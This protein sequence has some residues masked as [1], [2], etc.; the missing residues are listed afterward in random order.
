MD[1]LVILLI[2]LTIRTYFPKEKQESNHFHF[3]HQTFCSHVFS[4]LWICTCIKNFIN[5]HA[6]GQ[7]MK[8]KT[9]S[10][11][12]NQNLSFLLILNA[13][14]IIFF[15]YFTPDNHE[16]LRKIYS[17]VFNNFFHFFNN[18]P[19]IYSFKNHKQRILCKTLYQ[20]IASFF[21]TCVFTLKRGGFKTKLLYYHQKTVNIPVMNSLKTTYTKSNCQFR[22]PHT[23][24]I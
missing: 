3:L 23:T 5:I 4:A 9:P 14:C 8:I 18:M 2:C 19:G 20:H 1:S 15:Q 22:R 10:R 17:V 11:E 24:L 6:T 7:Q 12:H 16:L 13:K 21:F